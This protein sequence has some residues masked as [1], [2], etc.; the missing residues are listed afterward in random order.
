[1]R[2]RHGV[3]QLLTHRRTSATQVRHVATATQ[4]PGADNVRE[5]GHVAPVRG[6][7]SPKVLVL[8]CDLSAAHSAVDRQWCKPDRTGNKG[9]ARPPL[10]PHTYEMEVVPM[11]HTPQSDSSRSGQSEKA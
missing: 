9:T 10:M 11:R 8:Q 6:E 5:G 1:M 4:Q 3:E 7:R 2:P